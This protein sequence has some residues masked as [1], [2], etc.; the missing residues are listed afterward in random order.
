MSPSEKILDKLSKLRAAQEGEARIGNAAAAEAFANTINRMLLQHELSMEDVP[1]GGVVRDEPIVE[2]YADLAAHG[3]KFLN[4]RSGWQEA[5]ARIVAQAHLCKFLVATGSNWITFV[6]TKEHATVAAYAYGVLCSAAD[7]MSFQARE[8]WWKRECGG[9]HLASGNFRAGWIHGFVSRIAQR[10]AEARQAEVTATGNE[11]Q[12]LVRLSGALQRA[13]VF[14]DEK[15]KKKVAAPS[16]RTGNAA[17]YREGRA[18]ADAMKIGQKGVGTS[19][20]RQIGGKQ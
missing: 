11:S 4:V 15:Y 3:I 9:K 20:S 13:Q 1:V 16:M 18:A 17:G 12:A 5:L 6:G 10:F 7:R 19:S 2:L 8:D 14:V